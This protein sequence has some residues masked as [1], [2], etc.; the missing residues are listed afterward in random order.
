MEFRE[1]IKI[2]IDRLVK[3]F[4]SNPF[5]YLYEADIQAAL[6]A[7]AREEYGSVKVEMSGGYHRKTLGKESYV[8]TTTPVKCEYPSGNRFDI[9]VIDPE[10]LQSYDPSKGVDLGWKNDS[11]WG[12]PLCAAVEIKYMQLGDRFDR[13]ADG[14]LADIAKLKSYVLADQRFCGIALLFV[15][16]ESPRVSRRLVGLS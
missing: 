9:A 4:Q 3:D 8:V 10:R 6:F 2:S 7:M 13:R 11:F 14:F 5:D 12:Q 16:T 1:T 15:Q